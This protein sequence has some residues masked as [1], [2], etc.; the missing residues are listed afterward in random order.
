MNPAA[1]RAENGGRFTTLTREGDALTC[2]LQQFSA[3]FLMR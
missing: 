2:R 1:A 3:C